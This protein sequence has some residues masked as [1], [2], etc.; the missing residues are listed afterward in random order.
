[1]I[2]YN[3]LK[4]VIENNTSRSGKRFDYFIQ[5]L[6]ILSLISFSIETLPNLS[7]L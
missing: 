2:S 1:M 3:K 4:G 7:K 5:I 6:I